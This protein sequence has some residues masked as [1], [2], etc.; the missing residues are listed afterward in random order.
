MEDNYL[1]KVILSSVDSM[2][3]SKWQWPPGWDKKEKSKFLNECL[4]WLE[5]NEY[6]ERCKIIIN[7]KEKLSKKK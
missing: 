6:Y 1:D 7:E 2:S 3:K 4:D 5:K